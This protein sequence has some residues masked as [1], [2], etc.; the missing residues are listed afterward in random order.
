MGGHSSRSPPEK[1]WTVKRLEK[2][3]EQLKDQ[4]PVPMAFQ[5]TRYLAKKGLDPI[6]E[7]EA[8]WLEQFIHDNQREESLMYIKK[9]MINRQTAS[10]AADDALYGKSTGGM[11]AQNSANKSQSNQQNSAPATGGV[12]KPH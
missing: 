5:L 4:R 8:Q 1:Q 11:G 9:L 6:K 12:K 2:V 7:G 10:E 3:F